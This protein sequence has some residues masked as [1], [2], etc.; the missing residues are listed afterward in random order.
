M[1]FY[2]IRLPPF[3]FSLE[4]F[5]PKMIFQFFPSCHQLVTG[6]ALAS[7]MGTVHTAASPAQN[8]PRTNAI[9]QDASKPVKAR[10]ADLLSRMTFLEQLAQ[11]RNVGGILGENASFDNTTLYS[12]N[13]GQGG[14]S[15]CKLQ[16]YL[17]NLRIL[18]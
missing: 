7:L 18:S 17:D 11:T 15:I 13:N 16:L 14:G 10:V 12:F 3:K 4:Q 1:H 8:E 6:A 5:F 2:S 9:Y